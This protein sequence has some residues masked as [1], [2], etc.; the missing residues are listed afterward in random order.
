[1]FPTEALSTTECASLPMGERLSH[2]LGPEDSSVVLL[3]R[4][5]PAVVILP[6]IPP[7]LGHFYIG[8]FSLSMERE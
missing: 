7:L 3:L 4:V 6:K 2:R 8:F 5:G 1:M